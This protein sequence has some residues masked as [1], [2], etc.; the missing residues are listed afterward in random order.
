MANSNTN[1]LVIA[2]YHYTTI[3]DAEEMVHSHLAFCKEIGIRG[4]IYIAHEGINGTISGTEDAC[5]KYMNHLKNDSRF[6]GIEFKIDKHHEHAFNRIHVRYKKEIVHSGLRNPNEIDPTKETGKHITGEE[7]AKMKEDEDTVVIDV[8][9]NYETRLG[10]F[11]NS[12]T[13]NIET[14]REFPNKVVE[15]EPYK[16]K[17]VITVCTGGIKCEKASAYLIKQGFKDVYQLHNGIIGYA[18]E[19]G[20]KDFDG[21]LYVFDGRVSIPINTVNP[22]AIANCKKCGTPTN[23]SLNCANVECNEQFNMCETCSEEMEGA[24][25]NTCK[26][27]PHKREYNGTGYY[28]RPAL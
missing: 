7:F 21:N 18:K 11:K 24:C 25:S 6:A 26:V 16:N 27:S 20:G 10:K 1:F 14:F 22:E 9:S 2:Y 23:R 28:T 19:T 13:L 17:K 15:L 4:R 3:C 5:T 12:I 8:R